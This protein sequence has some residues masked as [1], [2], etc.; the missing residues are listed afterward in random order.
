MSSECLRFSISFY[1]N[2]IRIN[3]CVPRLIYQETCYNQQAQV[4]GSPAHQGWIGWAHTEC[5]CHDLNLGCVQIV[6]P[7]PQSLSQPLATMFKL[8]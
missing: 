1:D 7:M 4:L 8:I 5:C 6:T 3:F 2:G